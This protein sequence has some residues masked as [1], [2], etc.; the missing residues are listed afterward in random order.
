MNN[1]SI[2][3]CGRSSLAGNPSGKISG[4]D[5]SKIGRYSSINSRLN[6]DSMASHILGSALANSSP[7]LLSVVDKETAHEGDKQQSHQHTGLRSAD[8]SSSSGLKSAAHAAKGGGSIKP[9]RTQSM[10]LMPSKSELGN[11]DL[12]MPSRPVSFPAW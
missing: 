4:H 1:L 6:A 9:G 7:D 12:L 5:A 10:L 2:L 3:T 11:F 8:S